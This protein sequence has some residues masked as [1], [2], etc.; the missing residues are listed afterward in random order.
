MDRA[1]QDGG[2][3]GGQCHAADEQGQQQDRHAFGVEAE[4]QFAT[5]VAGRTPATAGMVRPMLAS[6]E[7]IARLRLV[8]T[9]S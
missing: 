1:L 7:P 2:A 3:A 8:W 4:R 6:A 9:R 5:E